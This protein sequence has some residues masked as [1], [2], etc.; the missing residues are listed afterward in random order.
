MNRSIRFQTSASA[1]LVTATVALASVVASPVAGAQQA[2][3]A[4]EEV[5]V[6]AR[7]REESLLAVP[8]TV[9]AFTSD[10][11][12]RLGL[13]ELTNL[14][15]FTPG[16]FYSENSVGRGGRFNRRLIF[17]GMNPRTDRQTRQGATLFIDGAP[18]IGSEL[19]STDNYERIEIIKGPQSAYFGRSTFSGAINAVSRTPTGE[20]GGRV[21]A[22][23]AS[24]GSTDLSAQLEGALIADKLSFRVTGRDYRTD[25]EYRNSGNPN[26]RL[27][28]EATTDASLTLFATPTDRLTAKLRLHAWRD[29]DG[30]SVGIGISRPAYPGFFNCNPGGQA[31]GN[32]SWICGEIPVVGSAAVGMDTQLTPQLRNWFFSPAMRAR[33]MF[34]VPERFGLK[35]TAHEASLIVDYELGNGLTL[36]SITAAHKN[37]YSSFEDF[38]RRPSAGQ[39]G[40]IRAPG[41]PVSSSDSY[42]MTLTANED[43]FQELRLASSQDQRLRWMLGLSYFKVDASLLSVNTFGGLVPSPTTAIDVFE[44]ETTAVFGSVGF[45]ITDQL[46]LNVEGRYQRD[47]VV[48]GIL[49]QNP[50]SATFNSATPRV[51]LDYKPTENATL[52]LTYGKGTNPGQ[53]NANLLIRTPAELAQIVAAGGS[54]IKV[55]E[56]KLTN[57]E[58]GVKGRFLD[59]RAT[60]SLAVYMSDWSNIVAPEIITI[61]TAAGTPLLVQVN[62]TGGQADLFGVEFEGAII[63]VKN[64]RLEATYSLTQS[65]IKTFNSPDHLA[66]VGSRSLT[67]SNNQFS[68]APEHSGTLSATYFG[69][70]GADMNW[71]L[72]GDVIYRGSFWL[73]ESNLTKAGSVTTTNLR[74]G[75]ENDAWSFEAFA[76]NV[77]DEKGY[78]GLQRFPDFTGQSGAGTGPSQILAG[79]IP[80]ASFGVKASFSF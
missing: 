7:K 6:T 71:Y 23:V 31:S 54:G 65:K 70:A 55:D 43:F 25:G 32:G 49:G 73:T 56:E 8:I 45:D 69:S 36:S 59:G 48:E 67:G 60:A 9:T 74:L 12:E 21:S 63:P 14:V 17:R 75:L 11:I 72:R 42:N 29:D 16:F 26:E 41:V 53:F 28:A 35:R 15:D 40:G 66:L 1:A 19:G 30:P 46:T 39:T 2:G 51:I 77:F 18:V 64:V 44:P 24:F 22:E 13:K 20:W 38:D 61:T 34:D 78:S 33:Y 76:S 79:F 62:A 3:S 27:G 4:L 58:A 52:Y 57:L 50:L 80:R 37:D 68:R 5:T 47:K 10:D